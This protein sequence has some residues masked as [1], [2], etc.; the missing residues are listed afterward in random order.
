MRIHLASLLGAGCALTLLL[1]APGSTAAPVS[2]ARTST[3][4]LTPLAADRVTGGQLRG[5]TARPTVGYSLL[6]VS[7]DD[8]SAR[9]TGTVQVR[10]RA[11]GRWSGWHDLVADSED[12]PDTAEAT[13]SRARGATAPL[14]VGPSDG[15]EVRVSGAGPLPNGLRV[16]LVDPGDGPSAAAA[17]AA[18]PAE[19]APRV[20]PAAEHPAPRPGIV[21]RS[22]WGA[23][24]SLRE[25]GFVYTG[26]VRAVFVH[27]TDS[28]NDYNC[29]D[30]PRVIRAIY[31]YHVRSN[32]WRDLGY[33]FLV[34]RCGI[35]YEGRAGGVARS[36]LGA[37]TLGFNTD[38]AGVAAIGTYVSDPP[39]QA[40]LDGI[41]KIA[42]W[43]LGLTDQDA[44]GTTTLTS[45][46]DGS[47][48]P[49]GT[50]H[51]FDAISGHRDAFNTECPGDALFAKL[52]AIRD[53]AAHLQ[54][55]R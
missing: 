52:D 4:A 44:T 34:D 3:L 21:T 14:W 55:R 9:L 27:H 22:G 32:G 8:P 41:A 18:P 49:A 2:T 35:I 13:G 36:V 25:P 48:Y 46:N 17:A 10:T 53:R 31:Q 7:W 15:V 6:G 42:A 30:S 12:R 50:S 20:L 29:G 51:T 28:G 1:Q 43:K 38:S 24:E 45:T 11:A 39:P 33:N 19:R 16:E 40:Q 54:G 5:L 37:H 23:D 47:R 26:D